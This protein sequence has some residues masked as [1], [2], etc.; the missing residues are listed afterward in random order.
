[1]TLIE[2]IK[3]KLAALWTY[4]AHPAIESAT[5]AVEQWPVEIEDS[6][7]LVALHDHLGKI[8]NEGNRPLDSQHAS[9]LSALTAAVSPVRQPEAETP[10]SASPKTE[11]PT[12]GTSPSDPAP[13]TGEA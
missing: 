10:Y 5:Q 7:A 1:M 8:L 4:T 2:S 9:D 6:P 11:H 3:E 13:S 12:E